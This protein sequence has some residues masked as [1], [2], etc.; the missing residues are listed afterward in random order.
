MGRPA[1]D[2]VITAE[3]R[4]RRAL[5][6]S[7]PQIAAETGTAK[8]VV[9]RLVRDIAADARPAA[10][11]ARAEIAPA[12]LPRVHKLLAAGESRLAIARHLGVAKSVLYRELK[13]H[14]PKP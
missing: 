5:G 6:R 3:L 2:D 11:R 10:N 12:W 4:R 9:H 7:I 1:Y 14:P 13:K 8:S